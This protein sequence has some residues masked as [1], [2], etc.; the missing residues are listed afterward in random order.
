MAGRQL[1][2]EVRGRCMAVGQ[3]IGEV[4]GEEFFWKKMERTLDICGKSGILKAW[5]VCF[6]FNIEK[7]M[8]GTGSEFRIE[9]WL[10]KGSKKCWE[11]VRRKGVVKCEEQVRGNQERARDKTGGA[12]VGAGGIPADDRLFGKR[13]V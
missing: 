8:K 4:G 11:F 10:Q 13:K 7:E 6:T 5:K 1:I 3:L 2:G 9:A 12:G